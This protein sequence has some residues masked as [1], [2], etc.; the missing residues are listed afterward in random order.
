MK[1]TFDLNHEK[2]KYPRM[3]DATKNEIRKYIK[4]ERRRELPEGVDF[5][6]FDCKFGD[7]EA[8]AKTIHLSEIDA[9]I[10]DVEKRELTSF[11]LEILRKEGVRLKKEK[12]KPVVN[13][14]VPK[15]KGFGE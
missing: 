7:T 12:E 5:W 1:K 13:I 11:Y 9:C 2:I 10:A 6:D 14:V 4:R 3:I 15:P 8:D